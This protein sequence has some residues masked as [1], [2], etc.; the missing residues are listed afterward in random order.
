MIIRMGQRALIERI[1]PWLGGGFDIWLDCFKVPILF[2]RVPDEW[3]VGDM[4]EV[5]FTKVGHDQNRD[6]GAEKRE[7]K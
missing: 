1:S 5:S 7:G 2:N 4:I 3:K 6:G